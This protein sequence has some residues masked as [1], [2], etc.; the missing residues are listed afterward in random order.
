MA[1]QESAAAGRDGRAADVVIVG[2]SKLPVAI[3]RQ[4]HN[5]WRAVHDEEGSVEEE[6]EEEGE[7]QSR[8]DGRVGKHG[9]MTGGGGG[10]GSC[11]AARRRRRR[12]RRRGS[13]DE[14][15]DPATALSVVSEQLWGLQQKLVGTYMAVARARL[16]RAFPDPALATSSGNFKRKP[17][18]RTG[19][20]G[21]GNGKGS[22]S[23]KEVE[24]A[25]AGD[26]QT[27]AESGS[28]HVEED[29]PDEETRAELVR[30]ALDSLCAA[31]EHLVE[32]KSTLDR[33]SA[34]VL[35]GEEEGSEADVDEG[36]RNGGMQAAVVGDDRRIADAA[37]APAE[38]GVAVSRE[39]AE[40]LGALWK[41]SLS[42]ALARSGHESGNGS[43][44]IDS[45]RA[46]ARAARNPAG[47]SGTAADDDAPA[48]S[49]AARFRDADN[50][51]MGRLAWTRAARG[52]LESRRAELFELCG[53]VAHACVSLRARR[54]GAGA[55]MAASAGNTEA[56][57]SL[58]ARLQELLSST[59]PPLKLEDLDVC[60]GLHANV[61]EAFKGSVKH[62]GTTTS[63]KT[64]A[65]TSG[66]KGRG[67]N[68][69]LSQAGPG[70]NGSRLTLSGT[71]DSD[72]AATLAASMGGSTAPSVD[73]RLPIETC[74]HELA[75]TGRVPGDPTAWSLCLAAEACYE[76]ALLDLDRIGG[77]LIPDFG[78]TGAAAAAAGAVAFSAHRPGGNRLDA[79]R[80]IF[81]GV[82][83]AQ[84][85]IRKK[86][87]DASNELG[88]LMAQCAGLLVQAPAP[89]PLSPH[90]LSADKE[91]AQPASSIAPGGASAS[92]AAQPPQHPGP[93]C[94]MCV[95][96]AERWF[97][98]SLAQFREI[99]DPRNTALLLC[100]LASVERLKPRALTR[101]REACPTMVLPV[102]SGGGG[103]SGSK[104]GEGKEGSSS[105][106]R[107]RF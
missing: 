53:D 88:K 76:R 91:G 58:P 48:A 2:E 98:R 38:G 106:L 10:D 55:S 54:I 72:M 61:L 78:A 65:S 33:R 90:P 45:G 28:G 31:W 15:E 86:L 93:A 14:S 75:K 79:K 41:G 9:Q 81:T 105:Y 97:R 24:G 100:N 52:Q 89:A 26:D 63:T 42:E 92:A 62:G 57:R 22:R 40:K 7:Q 46:K 51:K 107:G 96:C 37:R 34:A 94:A 99:D 30:G 5:P 74:V 19:S 68:R 29:G 39:R 103:Q 6:E 82:P 27:G 101:L 64:G 21:N 87:G 95:A 49:G 73:P 17:G 85:R 66:K 36:V 18:M 44:G 71:D 16:G 25:A 83:K 84:A 69:G 47:V 35:T 32:A 67:S 20:G 104:S 56:Q 59:S 1:R 102:E 3:M 23:P 60:Q 77:V 70:A 50:D 11:V 8:D 13:Q 43:G 80:A 4:P 12:R